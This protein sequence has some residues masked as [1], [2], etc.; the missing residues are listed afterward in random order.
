MDKGCAGR[1]L[2]SKG[3]MRFSN[4]YFIMILI[5]FSCLSDILSKMT[6]QTFPVYLSTKSGNAFPWH[7]LEPVY[8]GLAVDIEVLG[9]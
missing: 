8:A 9:V 6:F 7:E 5:D 4:S 3:R 2:F 1:I